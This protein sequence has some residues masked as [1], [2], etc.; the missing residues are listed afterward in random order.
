MSN[1][2]QQAIMRR[3]HAEAL[4]YMESAE[5]NLKRAGREDNYYNDRK[6][7][8]TACGTAYHG[9]LIA[10]DTYLL[11]RG[12]KKSKGRKSIE[13]YDE[14][15]GK[16]NKRMLRHVDNAHEILL[17]FGYFDGTLD[18]RVVKA[19]F[20]EAYMLIDQIKPAE[21]SEDI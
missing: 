15:I 1:E 2:E 10:L 12:V 13:Y 17:L 9:V 4:L 18:A 16:L 6:H 11:L 8:R 21:T 20:D 5:E 14:Q 7:V 19:G 3:Y